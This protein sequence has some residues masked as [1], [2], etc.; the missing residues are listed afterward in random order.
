MFKIN[1]KEFRRRGES[2]QLKQVFKRLKI[3]KK[4]EKTYVKKQEDFGKKIDLGKN[5]N[6]GIPV[7]LGKALDFGKPIEY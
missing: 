6:L 5:L 1:K 2:K 4:P 3:E 7:E